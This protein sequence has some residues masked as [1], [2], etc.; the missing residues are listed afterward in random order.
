M[1]IQPV[2]LCGGS[3]TRLWPESRT[4]YP[5]QFMPLSS[6]SNLFKE[7]LRRIEG[8][9]DLQEPVIVSNDAYRFYASTAMDEA[10]KTG[11]VI[12]EPCPRNTA[13]AIAL[14]AF[15]ALLILKISAR[16]LSWPVPRL[17]P[18]GW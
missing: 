6:G 15:A 2:I 8:I 18:A 1:R 17:N 5:K 16:R 13:P 11:T 14:A 12:L 3:G 7:T 9:R 10:G 4:R